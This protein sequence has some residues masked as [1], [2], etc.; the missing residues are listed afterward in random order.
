MST[1][2]IVAM[3]LGALVVCI[4][5]PLLL[6][7]A[8]TLRWFGEAIKTKGRTRVFGAFVALIAV[9]MIWSGMSE[10]TGLAAV[11]FIVGVFFL[12]IAIPAL[13]LFPSFYMSIADSVLPADSGSNLFGWR[14]IGLVNVII[15]VAIFRVGMVAG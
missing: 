15:G 12:A 9:P 5:G 8:A 10:N 7:P 1:A 13:V 2:G 14:I 3:F 4:R 11:L 6:V